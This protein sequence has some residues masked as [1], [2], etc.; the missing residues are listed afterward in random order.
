MLYAP[1]VYVWDKLA[2]AKTGNGWVLS[3]WQI[4]QP[5]SN[6]L[7]ELAMPWDEAAVR[8]AAPP[9]AV[10]RPPRAARRPR[11][12]QRSRSAAHI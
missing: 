1:D 9:P 5:D 8:A 10:R 3:K 6:R 12:A 4:K 11:R 2:F 7:N